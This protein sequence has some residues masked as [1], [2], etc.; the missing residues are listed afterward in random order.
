MTTRQLLL[1]TAIVPALL[2]GLNPTARGAGYAI[3]EQ[4]A[5]GQGA[6]HAGSAARAED[7]STLFFNPAGMARLPG[8]QFSVSGTLILPQ[9]TLQ[10]GSASI[11][12]P[13]GTL[14]V[15]GTVG[16]DAGVNAGV[17][18]LYATAQIS[19]NWHLG[20]SVTAPY[21]LVTQYPPSS[22]ARYYA[23]T[24][25]LSTIDIA[26][27]ASWQALPSLAL[28]ASLIV[29]TASARLTNAVDFG[30]IG[31]GLG[32]APFGLLPGRADGIA[33]LKG[34]GT[35]VGWQ[36]GALYE[37]RAGTRVG[38][39]YRS[40]ITHTIDG[41]VEFENVPALLA[42]GFRGGSASAKVVTPS[43]VSLGIA[44]EIG[45]FTVL[46]GLTWTQWSHFHDLLVVY[47]G[48]QSLTE[49]N[50][51]DTVTVSAGVEYHI[52]DA[53]TVRTGVAWDQSPVPDETRTPR[54]PDGNRT[55]L[56]I[57][58]TW[59]A[60]RNLALSLAYSHIFI[61]DT[62]VALTDLGPGTP[63]FLRG[64]LNAN[65]SNQVNIIAAQATFRF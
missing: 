23:L 38:L 49:E 3:L 44:Q 47:Q 20:L 28:G 56:S 32:L 42:P 57:G 48:G 59:N 18:S 5:E 37:P 16:T 1:S 43:N 29:E 54:I 53:F 33:N 6:S 65:Y 62:K 19:P 12:I 61:A 46:G 51:H 9:S 41:T 58:G 40:A 35:A 26:P 31:A 8:Y 22:I 39:T 52:N 27:A 45:R 21:G 4:S 24:S 11:N 63:D 55:W 14:P 10:S 25:Q 50:W 34:S 60:T 7:P 36:V 17:P 2:L 30:S 13:G 64:N 15:I